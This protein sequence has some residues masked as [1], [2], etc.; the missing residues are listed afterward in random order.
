M[1]NV[2]NGLMDRLRA[3]GGPAAEVEEHHTETY[4]NGDTYSGGW[5]N[6]KREGSGVLTCANGD[7]YVGQ[8]KNDKRHGKGKRKSHDEMG[9]YIYDGEWN[10]DQR[11][12]YGTLEYLPSFEK[13]ESEWK[14][15]EWTGKKDWFSFYQKHDAYTGQWKYD[16][17]NGKGHESIRGS[18]GWFLHNGYW[19]NDQKHGI[20]YRRY[21]TSES[22]EEV[23]SKLYGT[24]QN[25]E[26]IIEDDYLVKSNGTFQR[27]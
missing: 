19:K 2:V 13:W 24:W 1:T 6:N 15:D 7:A 21:Y 22:S 9:W 18:V 27:I 11:H 23:K 10:T 20:G 26:M 4:S 3:L 16:K 5:R 17:R 25:D 14:N 12:G 8:W